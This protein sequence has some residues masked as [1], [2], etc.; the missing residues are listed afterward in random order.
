[1]KDDLTE[2]EMCG[3]IYFEVF[4]RVLNPD[5]AEALCSILKRIAGVEDVYRASKPRRGRYDTFTVHV[6]GSR[7]QYFTSI[8]RDVT[9]RAHTFQVK[10]I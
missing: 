10:N 6:D 7:A 3:P 2:S 5:E 9:T 1:M 4:I 8:Y